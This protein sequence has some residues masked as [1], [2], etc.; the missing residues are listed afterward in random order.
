MSHN[1][2]I[3]TEGLTRSLRRTVTKNDDGIMGEI[4]R[5]LRQE[6]STE[7]SEQPLHAPP[8]ISGLFQKS[9]TTGLTK[10]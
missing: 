2:K 3:S 8:E 4:E 7:G 6:L 9:L 10:V 1:N 5:A